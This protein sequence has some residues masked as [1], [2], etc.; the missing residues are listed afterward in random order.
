M[1][2]T[3]SNNDPSAR[4]H[5]EADL[6]RSLAHDVNG[7][8]RGDGQLATLIAYVGKGPGAEWESLM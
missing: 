7:D 5:S 6:I 1:F 8:D 2:A 3:R 4:M